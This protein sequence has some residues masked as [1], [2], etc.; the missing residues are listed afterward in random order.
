MVDTRQ[1]RRRLLQSGLGGAVALAAAQAGILGVPAGARADAASVLPGEIRL[2]GGDFAPPGWDLAPA[3]AGRALMGEGTAPSGP[4]RR[5]G[6]RGDGA[7]DR[8]RD[9]EASTLNLTYL[10]ARNHD[11]LDPFIGE[12]RAFTGELPR[13]DRG[14]LREKNRTP[15]ST[16]PTCAGASPPAPPASGP[17]AQPAASVPRTRR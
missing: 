1:T 8:D 12:I 6:E 11:A 17:P 14:P 2:F 9:H 10:V 3:L 7:V 16:C 15:T 13:R 5:A 4:D